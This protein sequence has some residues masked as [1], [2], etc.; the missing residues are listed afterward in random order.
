MIYID[1][2]YKF[3]I[4]WHFLDIFAKMT[5]RKDKL[6][7]FI[8]FYTKPTVIVSSN[9]KLIYLNMPHHV[10]I[11]KSGNVTTTIFENNFFIAKTFGNAISLY[12]FKY[13]FTKIKQKCL[14]W[15]FFTEKQL[16]NTWL[17]HISVHCI[18]LRYYVVNVNF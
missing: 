4:Y 12:I 17:W 1:A 16:F 11:K 2:L 14:R 6:T 13:I 5:F 8:W 15:H 18:N 9:V 7:F 10:L 3:E